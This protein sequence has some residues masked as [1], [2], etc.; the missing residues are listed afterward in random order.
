MFWH[1]MRRPLDLHRNLQ[2]FLSYSLGTAVIAY[3]QGA[4]EWSAYFLGLLVLVSLSITMKLVEQFF[5]PEAA[6][7]ETLQKS[8]KLDQARKPGDG[9]IIDRP[10]YMLLLLAMPFLLLFLMSLWTLFSSGAMTGSALVMVLM[11]AFLNALAN[12]P[13]LH[14]SQSKFRD[15]ID[16]AALILFPAGFGNLLQSEMVIDLSL[17]L[18][19]SLLM[20]FFAL[21]IVLGL[22][23]YD[24]DERLERDTFLH[25]VGWER[26]MK[27]HNILLLVAF[28]IPAL[29]LVLFDFP[30]ELFW[31]LLLAFAVAVTQLVQMV[32]I[33]NGA[34]VN[35][36]LL[37]F[38]AY[39]SFYLFVYLN[40]L[41]LLIR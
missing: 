6:L 20:L 22:E 15:L 12:F 13:P 23:S 24:E 2:L 17:I 19:L 18:S 25:A 38:T 5:F 4:I 28:F 10:R 36:R 3:A 40:L 21:R 37:R 16:G 11:I 8:L 7:L 27:A 34:P 39:A 41:T 33:H 29:A 32:R 1:M 30:L 14:L 31:P 9:I 26:G 35:W